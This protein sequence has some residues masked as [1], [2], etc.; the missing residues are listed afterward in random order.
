MTSLCIYRPL[1]WPL[2]R[3]ASGYALM[4]AEEVVLSLS[5]SR[6]PAFVTR[7]EHSANA[8]SHKWDGGILGTDLAQ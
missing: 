4:E 8:R 5:V 2:S 7:S 6:S 1:P 3:D